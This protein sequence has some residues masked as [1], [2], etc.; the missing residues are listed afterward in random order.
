MVGTGQRGAARPGPL[1]QLAAPARAGQ[2]TQAAGAARVQPAVRGQCLKILRLL[3][4]RG[5]M[6]REEICRATGIRECSACG[7]LAALEH[8]G[9]G[10]PFGLADGTALVRRAGTRRSSAGVEVTCYAATAAGLREAS[11]PA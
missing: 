1:F 8:P 10:R 4:A 3:I 6:T 9:D 2:P 5:P 11:P 7:R